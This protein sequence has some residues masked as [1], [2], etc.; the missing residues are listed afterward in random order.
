MANFWK[1]KG[2]VSIVQAC[3]LV[4][5]LVVGACAPAPEVGEEKEIKI[6]LQAALTGPVAGGALPL[7]Y[8]IF[9]YVT[10][11]NERGG[12]DGIPLHGT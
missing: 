9:D 12:V 10:L 2:L 8:G 6:G 1:S 5:A 3:A 7:N 4:L 11:I